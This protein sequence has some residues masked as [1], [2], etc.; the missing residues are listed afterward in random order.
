MSAK[1]QKVPMIDTLGGIVK[2]EGEYST[3]SSENEPETN[4][5]ELG[6]SKYEGVSGD[7]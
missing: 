5:L 1:S 3:S 7:T 2:E 6:V 4:K